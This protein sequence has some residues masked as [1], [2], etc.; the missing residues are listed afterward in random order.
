M[1]RIDESRIEP[2]T[3]QDE[4]SLSV[5]SRERALDVAQMIQRAKANGLARPFR[6]PCKHDT[7][8]LSCYDF[9][10]AFRL[11][12]WVVRRWLGYRSPPR[13]NSFDPANRP[14]VGPVQHPRS[15]DLLEGRF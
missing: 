11:P 8:S 13:A 15:A 4:L 10:L 14:G 9:D 7:G 3:E 1:R 6:L 2:T 5:S 12:T